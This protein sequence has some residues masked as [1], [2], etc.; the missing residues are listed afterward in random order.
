MLILVT[1]KKKSKPN[2]IP[3]ATDRE[4]GFPPVPRQRGFTL[5]EILVVVTLLGFVLGIATL[6]VG[7]NEAREL[8]LFVRHAH[9]V[10]ELA[11]EEAELQSTQLGLRVDNSSLRF[12]AFDVVENSWQALQDKPFQPLEVPAQVQVKL[13]VEDFAGQEDT[14][15]GDGG[16]Q[17]PQIV[18][19]SSGETTA[20]TLLLQPARGEAYRLLSDGLNLTLEEDTL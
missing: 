11:A 2:R 7:G 1:G 4:T 16:E 19:L 15:L 13:D 12:V 8:R 10:L 5:L 20:Y 17:Q 6:N 14:L 18:F 3:L 9:A